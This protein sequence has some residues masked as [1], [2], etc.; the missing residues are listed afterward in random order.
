MAWMVL[1]S[2]IYFVIFSLVVNANGLGSS[3]IFKV[4]PFFCGM[5]CVISGLEMLNI[6]SIL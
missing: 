5:A 2:G 6:I 3:V 1:I 4:L